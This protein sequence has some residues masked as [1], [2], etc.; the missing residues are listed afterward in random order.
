M[1]VFENVFSNMFTLDNQYYINFADVPTVLA[2]LTDLNMTGTNFF[3]N[4]FVFD[5]LLL[6]ITSPTQHLGIP[7]NK[8]FTMFT[9][10]LFITTA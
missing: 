9:V 8:M 3:Y 2:T 10:K 1:F 7:L 4:R 5:I 6:T